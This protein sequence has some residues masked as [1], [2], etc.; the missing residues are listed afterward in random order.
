MKL[1]NE[2]RKIYTKK[3][4]GAEREKLPNGIYMKK[5]EGEGGGGLNI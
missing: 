1:R 2:S 5:E 3:G 4:K